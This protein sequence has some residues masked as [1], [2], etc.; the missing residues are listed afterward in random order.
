[1]FKRQLTT[2][3]VFG[4]AAM[5]PPA[6]AQQPACGERDSLTERLES[7]YNEHQTGLGLQTNNRL[8]EIWTSQDTGS[9]TIIVTLAD[10]TSCILATGENWHHET[11]ALN[12]ELGVPSSYAF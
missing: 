7:R 1:M 2:A 3:L 6:F 5:A 8:V 10:G 9:W 11:P 12:A 4:M